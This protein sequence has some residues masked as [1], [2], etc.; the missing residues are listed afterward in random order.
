MMLLLCLNKVLMYIY[1]CICMYVRWWQIDK[2]G[3]DDCVCPLLGRLPNDKGGD[4]CQK[5]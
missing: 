1:V 4:G 3:I 5:I 2:D